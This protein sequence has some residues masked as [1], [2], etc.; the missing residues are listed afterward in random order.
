MDA[1]F[2][3]DVIHELKEKEKEQRRKER[4][5]KKA[6]DDY[7]PGQEPIEEEK[8]SFNLNS[9]SVFLTYPHC[10]DMRPEDFLDC[11][12]EKMGEELLEWHIC[13]EKHK[14]GDNHAHA[15]LKFK[16]KMRVRRADFFDAYWYHPHIESTKSWNKVLG[17]IY[18]GD[19]DGGK[20]VVLNNVKFDWTK[21]NGFER[22]RK[23]YMQWKRELL[24]ARRAETID[25]LDVY[26]HLYEMDMKQKKR[27]IW[28]H[29]PA[30]CGK[31]TQ[32]M[33]NFRDKV[34]HFKAGTPAPGNTGLYGT[35]DRYAG[36]RYLV[37]DDNENGLN[38]ANIC[39]LSNV[40]DDDIGESPVRGRNQDPVFYRTIVMI[41]MSNH[42]PGFHHTEDWRDADWFKARFC[43]LEVDKVDGEGVIVKE[44]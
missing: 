16:K 32:V 19:D 27:H 23:D 10:D 4:E 31:T 24:Q 20:P 36:E 43:C 21:H 14:T 1:K 37:W 5:D 2:I 25:F 28:I 38:K 44:T 6:A 11:F 39:V 30:N 35:F 7:V 40:G 18:K 34:Q 12:K 3:A 41:V 9:R 15:L 22:R 42:H 8:E 33:K 13:L 17:Y 26:E 29:G